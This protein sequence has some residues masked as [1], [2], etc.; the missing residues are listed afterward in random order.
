MNYFKSNSFKK[1]MKNIIINIQYCC[2]NNKNIPKKLYF[3]KWIQ[4]ILCKK[5]YKHYNNPYC[6]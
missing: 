3:K 5:K 6:R 1:N 2:K 4:K